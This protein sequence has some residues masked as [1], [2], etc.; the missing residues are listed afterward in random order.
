MISNVPKL[1]LLVLR[2]VD[3]SA[4]ASFYTKLGFTFKLH[5]H[6]QGVEHFCSDESELVLEIYPVASEESTTA[7][8][9]LGFRVAAV[10]T[11]HAALL[12]AGAKELRAPSDSEW[13]R[14]SV[15]ED[16]AGHKIELTC[17]ER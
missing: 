8:L 7:G 5:K 10:D 6:G 15:L 4:L 1:N 17:L 12:A 16:P 11:Q 14:R 9:R 2:V 13:G 3:A